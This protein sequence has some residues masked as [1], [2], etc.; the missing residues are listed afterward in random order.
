MLEFKIYLNDI[1]GIGVD[2]RS[3]PEAKYLKARRL[4]SSLSSPAINESNNPKNMP[5]KD[6]QDT[7]LNTQIPTEMMIIDSAV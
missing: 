6:K 5:G 3:D 7:I 1:E 2:H 4:L